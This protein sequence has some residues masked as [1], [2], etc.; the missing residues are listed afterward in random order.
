MSSS[1]ADT[2]DTI[3]P[4]LVER[5]RDGQAANGPLVFTF[6]EAVKLG[7]NASIRVYPGTKA[8]ITIALADNL[9]VTLSG[10]T[11]TVQLPQ[12]LDYATS[13]AAQFSAGAIVDLA[14]N[15]VSGG[16]SF[17][18]SFRSGLSPVALDLS[19]TSGNDTLDGS[20]LDDTI[21]GGAGADTL[22]GH[23]GNDLLYGGPDAGV[24]RI[25][26]GAGDDGLWGGGG[27][28][29]LN[30]GSGNDR[31]YGEGGNDRL[32]GDEGDDLLEGGAGDD[33][34]NGGTGA[35]TLRGGEGKDTLVGSAGSEYDGGAGD[36]VFIVNYNAQSS[37]PTV[38]RGG[39]G[40]DTFHLGLLPSPAGTT[41]IS[42]GAGTDTYVPTT[43]NFASFPD[44]TITDFTPG[45]GGDLI[46]VRSVVSGSG[47]ERNPFDGGLRLLGSGSDTLLQQRLL[48][49]GAW[50]TVLTL[51]GIAP[52]QLLAANFVEGFDPL[53]GTVGLTLTGTAD[54]DTLNG[55]RLD[56]SLFG[57]GGNDLLEGG[58]GNDLLEGGDGNDTLNGDVGNDTLR[59]GAGD[60]T[61][62]ASLFG[63]NLLEGGAGNDRLRSYGGGNDRL[64]GGD[65]DDSLLLMEHSSGVR[66]A[67]ITLSGGAGNDRI[68]I[69]SMGR[70]ASVIA[71]G[72]EGADLF[73]LG[74]IAG[75]GKLRIL[76]FGAADQLDLQEWLPY[77]ITDN[78][79]G[80]G[81]YWKA[82][83]EGAD[84]GIYVDRDGT[85]PLP[86]GLLLTLADV[87]LASLSGANF[88]GGFDPAGGSLGN[89]GPIGL[90]LTGSAGDD[91]LSGRDLNDTIDGRA[92]NDDLRGEAGD[93]KLFGGDGHDR[94]DGGAGNDH[95]EGGDGNDTL[96]DGFGDDVLIGGAGDDILSDGTGDNVLSGGAGN[97]VLSSIGSAG[98]R[99]AGTILDGGDGNDRFH[100]GST[101]KTVLGGAGDDDV[102]V[103]DE[104]GPAGRAPLLVDLGDGN[105]RLSFSA[106][107]EEA[108]A[109]RVSGG[110]GVDSYRF[111]G[112]YH[113]PLLT[114]TD[115]QTGAGGDVLD[116]YTFA[117]ASRDSNPFAAAG[118]ARLLQ[119]GSHVLLQ[120][121][122]PEAGA[123]SWVT[124]VVFENTRVAD[125]TAANFTDNA[126][127]NAE[128]GGLVL[129]GTA[130][131][132][133]LFGGMLADVLRGGDGDDELFGNGGADQLYGDD[134]NDFL[135]AGDGNDRLD[136]GAGD[137]VLNGEAG[138]D[139]LLGGAG[140]DTM[141]DRLG[142]NVL[143]GGEGNDQIHTGANGSAQVFGEAGDDLLFIAGSGRYD[144]GDGH[145]SFFI[146]LDKAATATL[147]LTGGAGRDSYTPSGAA[148]GATVTITDFAVGAGG[149]FI[150]VDKLPP[151]G[152]PFAPGGSLQFVQRGAD[153][154][155]QLRVSQDSSASFQDV[156][157]LRDVVRTALT[158]ENIVLGFDPH[159]S[160]RGLSVHGTDGADKLAGTVHEDMLRGGAGNDVLIG[161]GGYDLL[162][163]GAGIDT[164]VFTGA[165]S[166]YKV[167]RLPHAPQDPLDMVV[168][169]VRPGPGDGKDRL[170]GIERLV[171]ADGAIAFDTG[172][173]DVAGQAY[174]IYRAAFDRTPD[175]GGLGFWI[176]AMD[177]GS[178]LAE[179]ASGF[180]RSQ[181][182]IDLYG[183]APTNAEIVTRMYTNIL[184]RAPERAGYDYWLAALDNKVVDV[185]AMLAMFSQ[186]N[187]NYAAVA[188]LIS[189]GIA[190]QPF[191][192]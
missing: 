101:V 133:L 14:G 53:G 26:G 47:E 39:D 37:G 139:E 128:P 63:D 174:R 62:N 109:V 190:Y 56:D 66:G 121:I 123:A 60:D 93:D 10:A 132:D 94:L 38:M 87:A 113:W 80:A 136:G 140:N 170:T 147:L 154:V 127:P 129:N 59:G 78:P 29:E 71:S 12:Q 88:V 48:A 105:D 36:D 184:D 169:D 83:Q 74:G 35:N 95:L 103:D 19:G 100:V 21:D 116:V 153:T 76:D 155:L 11:L 30:G 191:G 52:S 183:A 43:G 168:S 142:N 58:E 3:A 149:D 25:N 42:G 165:R 20:D 118:N 148:P 158:S 68:S 171:F 112:G 67:T 175:Q 135:F 110:A 22:N 18:V 89:N 9:A 161:G 163:G 160:L 69:V 17:N 104:G 178:T 24:D 50:V 73:H 54:S 177:R 179:I 185:A 31:L 176:A 156:L 90:T 162:D 44:I 125:F 173:R 84:V 55:G 7:P 98:N 28:D 126:R 72:G 57:L 122:P 6:S 117:P 144:G 145:D 79:F 111:G 16:S 181:E 138:D 192:G 2:A 51:A 64:L 77:G 167:E 75:G 166:Q 106:F 92:G 134:G 151:A 137:D 130:A 108:R 81:G 120:V 131:G 70:A 85:G 102:T 157:I 107:Y 8:G 91:V 15:P 114:I 13:Y 41:L 86:A 4:T 23:G 146:S 34:L 172:V 124:R 143:R 33:M 182:F 40:S 189:D 119:E 141:E 1:A 49:S 61:L 187:E 99:P 96:S 164:A 186:S 65:G 45:A 32:N 27:N 82:V 152:N 188:E 97:D 159:G 150:N 5:P 115:F 180:V 46:D